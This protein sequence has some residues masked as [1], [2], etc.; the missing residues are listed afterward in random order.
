M[1]LRDLTG[2]IFA[3]LKVL[4]RSKVNKRGKP[5]W[6]CI[7]ECGNEKIVA[8]HDLISG[9]TKSCGCYLKEHIKRIRKPR[10]KGKRFSE[11]ERFDRLKIIFWSKVEKTDDCWVWKASKD[12]YGYGHFRY[13]KIYTA[14]R[15]SYFLHYGEL[16]IGKIICHTCDVRDCVNPKHLYAGTHKT[17][18]DD[19]ISRGRSRF[20]PRTGKKNKKGAMT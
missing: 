11:H 4:E 10:P 12:R 2:K 6:N 7:C 19:K 5:A 13:D 3:R 9:D 17:N 15:F 18:S 1:K 20:V 16:E 14:H 8:S